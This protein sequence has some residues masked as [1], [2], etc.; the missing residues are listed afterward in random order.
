MILV[1]CGFDEACKETPPCGRSES[2]VSNLFGVPRWKARSETRISR[3]A[4]TRH[5]LATPWLAYRIFS[6]TSRLSAD[7]ATPLR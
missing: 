3:C 1:G 2:A 4:A 5:A 6:A 7:L